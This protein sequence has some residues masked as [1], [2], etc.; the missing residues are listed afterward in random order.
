[1]TLGA[2]STLPGPLNATGY[3]RIQSANPVAG[4]KRIRGGPIVNSI[5]MRAPKVLG[6]GLYGSSTQNFMKEPTMKEF[7][8]EGTS[9]G[10]FSIHGGT[11][12]VQSANTV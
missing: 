9:T 6:Q 1:M 12:R 2:G 7:T 10:V 11:M 8:Q 3:S 5:D 4:S